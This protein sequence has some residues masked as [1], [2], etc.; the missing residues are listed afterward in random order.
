MSK[1]A[2]SVNEQKQNAVRSKLS[3]FYTLEKRQKSDSNAG[4]EAQSPKT[5]PDLSTSTDLGGSKKHENNSY[6]LNHV[7]VSHKFGSLY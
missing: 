7:K 1:M 5:T 3:S 2:K 4:R 6:L